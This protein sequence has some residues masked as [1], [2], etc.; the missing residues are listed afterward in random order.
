MFALTS[1]QPD[2]RS[3]LLPVVQGRAF[4]AESLFDLTRTG[5]RSCPIF[6]PL[7]H[8]VLNE[9]LATVFEIHQFTQ[10]SPLTDLDG[11]I[12]EKRH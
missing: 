5:N 9:A 12:D 11:L 10:S 6:Q 1:E 7:N 3:T 2:D 4:G 8:C